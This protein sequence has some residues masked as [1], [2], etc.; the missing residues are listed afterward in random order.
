MS[1]W[2]LEKIIRII[3]IAMNVILY[4]CKSFGFEEKEV[5]E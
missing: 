5:A 1:A 2:S 4:A 3:E